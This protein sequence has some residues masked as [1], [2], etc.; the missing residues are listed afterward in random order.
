MFEH[1]PRGGFNDICLQ[2]AMQEAVSDSLL[3]VANGQHGTLVVQAQHFAAALLPIAI[4]I[5]DDL[6]AGNLVAAQAA[7]CHLFDLHVGTIEVDRRV[8]G[9][10]ALAI[11]AIDE[12]NSLEAQ[13]NNGAV[14]L[15]VCLCIE[16][17]DP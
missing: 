14:A 17:F 13:F 15:R 6:A 7:P 2:H 11:V 5:A 9:Q 3:L 1:G 12:Q 16:I 10:S 4:E 8:I